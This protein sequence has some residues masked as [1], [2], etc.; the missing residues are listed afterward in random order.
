MNTL[1][2]ID[3]R[4][5][6]AD[7]AT[8]GTINVVN[9]FTGNQTFY[10]DVIMQKTSKIYFG[11]EHDMTRCKLYVREGRLYFHSPELG[12]YALTP[13]KEERVKRV[14]DTLDE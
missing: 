9:G 6:N 1:D 2:N 4:S 8:V 3:T 11:S 13:S 12:E 7:Y 14:I 5:I 10:G